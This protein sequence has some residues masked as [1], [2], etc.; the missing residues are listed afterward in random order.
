MRRAALLLVLLV[1]ATHAAEKADRIFINGRIWTGDPGRPRVEALAVRDT[2]ILAVGSTSEVRALA[3]KG[4][5]V[6]DLQ[7][8]FACPGFIDAHL[9]F[10]GGALSLDA[11]RL[12]GATSLAEVEKHIRDYARA[13]PDTAWIAGEGWTYGAFPGGMP[14]LAQLEAIV[15]DRLVFLRSYDGH[16]AWVSALALA[17][18]GITRATTDPPGGAILRDTQGDATGILK[19]SAVRLV[20]Q[21]VPTPAPFEKYKAFRK[22]LE[23]AASYGLTSVHQASFDEEDLKIVEQVLDERGLKVRFY[24]SVPMV[25]APPAE[26]L[27]RYDELRKKHV[28][29]LLRF[30]AVKG[31]VDGV[32]ESRTAAMFEPY[33]AGGTGLPRWTQEDLDRTVALYDKAG[34]QVFLHAIGDRAIAMALSAYEQAA[35]ANGTRGRRHRIEHIEVPRPE[36]LPRFK[37]LGV[38][39][40][41]QALFANPDQNHLEVYL[42]TLGPVR[43]ARAMPFK[44]I[45]DAGAVQAFGSDWPV[46]S[47]EVL[48]G[49]YC[50]VTRTTPEGTPAGGWEP[51][52]R[53]S[54]E[55]ALRHF[56]RDAAFA[57]REDDV[58]GTLAPGKLADLVVLSDDIL[59]IP[60]A[61]LLKTRVLLTVLGGQDTYRAKELPWRST[62]AR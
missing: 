22:G 7:G 3:E 35:K 52:N 62:P 47:C 55:A 31:F 17:K 48:R 15:P 18:A 16:T 40:S 58:K 13:H 54:A 53:I 5:D 33:A 39:A 20:S 12:D 10:M 59:A 2:K 6:V 19:E 43:A 11:L 30:G 1:P 49:I 23:L 34:Y 27:A 28:G 61:G 21:L 57:G 60:S 37:A 14:T 36:D 42:P 56:T 4:T 25:Q 32:V 26:T 29:P 9:H 41:T 50:A 24:A 51:G 38:I 46:F 8:R 44:A 45:D